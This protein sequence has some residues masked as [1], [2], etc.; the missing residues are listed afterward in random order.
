M[1]QKEVSRLP[2]SFYNVGLNRY[3]E[4]IKHEK[5]CMVCLQD[6]KIGDH[7]RGLRCMH[8]FHLKCID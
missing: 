2:T 4:I 3:D 6:F 7:V 5:S 1:T 8:I